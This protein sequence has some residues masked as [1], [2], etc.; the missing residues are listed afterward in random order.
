MIQLRSVSEKW[1]E[2]FKHKNNLSKSDPFCAAGDANG[3]GR[4]FTTNTA[5][6]AGGLASYVEV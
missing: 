6:A 5:I 2:I 1:L 4:I 3:T